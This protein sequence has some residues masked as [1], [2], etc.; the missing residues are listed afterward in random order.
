MAKRFRT[1]L[2]SLLIPSLF[3]CDADSGRVAQIALDPGQTRAYRTAC[4][5][6]HARPD[7]G[8][9]LTG[10]DA[11]WRER[12]K[13]GIEGLLVSTVNGFRGMPPLGTCGLCSE[14][15][16]RALIRYMAGLP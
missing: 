6:C 10:I 9:P 7:I 5:A 2:L 11:D 15:D 16:F 14:N 4:A 13:K 1:A 8:A 3:A 12:R